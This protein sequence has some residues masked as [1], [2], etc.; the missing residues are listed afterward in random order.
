MTIGDGLA[1]IGGAVACV[2]FAWAAAWASVRS[3]AIRSE[4]LARLGPGAPKGRA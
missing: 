3:T 1:V 2:G 4:T